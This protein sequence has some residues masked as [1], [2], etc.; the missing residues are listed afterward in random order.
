MFA[1]SKTDLIEVV[2]C[3]Y[4]SNR[5]PLFSEPHHPQPHARCP[6]RCA[7]RAARAAR[8]DTAATQAFIGGAPFGI[9]NVSRLPQGWCR[10]G[11]AR[12]DPP[13]WN[14][15]CAPAL[16]YEPR[17]V[18]V[19]IGRENR[20]SKSGDP[21]R[22]NQ[23][24]EHSQK[25]LRPADA[26]WAAQQRPSAAT[27]GQEDGAQRRKGNGDDIS[28]RTLLLC[29]YIVCIRKRDTGTQVGSCPLLSAAC[30][31]LPACL[32]LHSTYHTT[33]HWGHRPAFQYATWSPSGVNKGG[34]G[35]QVHPSGA[36]GMDQSV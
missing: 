7:A 14:L 1:C 6:L 27:A 20:S 17:C 29:M 18:E 19:G 24:R 33:T 12:R 13:C 35:V 9:G 5:L 2:H 26:R 23:R 4:L 30:R 22:T 25:G 34:W 10:C 15:L 3:L 31:A 8:G 16:D 11:P 36:G 21:P 28:E 32:G